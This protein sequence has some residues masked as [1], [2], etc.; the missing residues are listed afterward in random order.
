[1]S[2][3]RPLDSLWCNSKGFVVEY[4]FT[5]DLQVLLA[6]P[7]EKKPGCYS[8]LEFCDTTNSHER[9]LQWLKRLCP[10]H[11]IDST[12]KAIR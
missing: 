8:H 4:P 7:K 1:M 12:M 11:S 3:L 6:F 9:A 2:T 5:G 10:T